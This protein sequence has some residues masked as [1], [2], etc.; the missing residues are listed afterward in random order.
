[1]DTD[2]TILVCECA[3][4]QLLDQRSLD[5]AC[6]QD[7]AISVPDLC[8]LAAKVDPALSDWAGRPALRIYACHPRAVRALFA[9]ANAPLP[10]NTEFVN[11]RSPAGGVPSPTP[12][13]WPPWFPVIDR[14]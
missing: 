11:M 3:E 4:R 6:R 8:G 2:K 5:D 14:A 10:D 13:A 1:M 9:H 12:A 7:G